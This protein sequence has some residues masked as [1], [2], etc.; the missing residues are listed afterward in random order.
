MSAVA[1]VLPDTD[2][3]CTNTHAQ[4]QDGDVVVTP[5]AETPGRF[6]VYQVPGT[7]SLRWDSRVKAVDMARGFAR[8][9]RV[10]VWFSGGATAER[11][12]CHRAGSVQH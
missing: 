11:L 10:D 7:P 2:V 12:H 3:V 4:P 9:H 8:A 5:D 6:T 1:M